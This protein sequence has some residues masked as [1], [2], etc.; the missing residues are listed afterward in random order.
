[1]S[2]P[3]HRAGEVSPSR[4]AA[5]LYLRGGTT[6]REAGERYG[7]TWR[8]VHDVVQRIREQGMGGWPEDEV[9]C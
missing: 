9:T 8:S 3:R 2:A 5:L 6:L 7:V 1:M 4:K